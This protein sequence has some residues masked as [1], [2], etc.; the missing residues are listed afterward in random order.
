MTKHEDQL[1]AP[2]AQAELAVIDATLRGERVPEEHAQLFALVRAVRETRSVPHEHFVRVLDERAAEGFAHKRRRRVKTLVGSRALA[3]LAVAALIA[4]A[5]VIPV[6]LKGGNSSGS[7]SHSAAEPRIAAGAKAGRSVPTPSGRPMPGHTFGG[8]TETA[9]SVPAVPSSAV[10]G[11]S[12]A[13]TAAAEGAR[14]VEHAASL[15]VGVA[16]SSIQSAAQQVFSIVAA[17][18]G[19]AQQSSVSSGGGEQGGASFQLRVPS[20]SLPGALAALAH[21]GHVRSENET[22]NDVTEALG[23]LQRSLGEAKAERASLLAQLARTSEAEAAEALKRKLHAVDA[24][25]AQLQS[26]IQALTKRVDYTTLA[27]SLTP[28]RQSGASAGDLTPSGAL[29]DAGLILGAG[30]SLLVL[31]VAVLL[32]L[33]IVVLAIGFAL[34][35]ARRRVR[36]RA[37]DAG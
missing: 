4:V 14:Q 8:E 7:A 1:I 12:S 6:G 10:K 11:A 28:E 9:P 24:R 3:S 25:I 20:T 16:S 23:S 37:L 32:P 31:A 36:E 30:L 35:T 33:A 19:Y 34:A 27:F 2:E 15:D 26:S 5:I 18:H 22:T 13:P 21:L 17:F 29:H